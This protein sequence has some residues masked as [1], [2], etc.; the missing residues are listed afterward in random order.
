MCVP[1]A[2]IEGLAPTSSCPP[3]RLLSLPGEAGGPGLG[4]PGRD[5]PRWVTASYVL[6]SCCDV[7]RQCIVCHA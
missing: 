6:H 5:R 7:P 1:A 4:A 3:L 2:R